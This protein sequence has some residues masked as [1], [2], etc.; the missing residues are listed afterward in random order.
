MDF[1]YKKNDN[2][3]LFKSLEENPGFGILTP[4]NYIPLYNLYFALSPTNNNNII[5]NQRWQL[6][7]LNAQETTNIFKCSVKDDKKKR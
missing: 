6:N 2:Q 4:Q 7:R 5:L 1:S 3:Q